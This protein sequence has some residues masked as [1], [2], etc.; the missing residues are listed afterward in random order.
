MCVSTAAFIYRSFCSVRAFVLFD[1]RAGGPSGA[2]YCVVHIYSCTMLLSSSALLACRN[3]IYRWHASLPRA[4]RPGRPPYVPASFPVPTCTPGS[5]GASAH[6]CA[7]ALL[8]V[9][10]TCSFCLWLLRFV[11]HALVCCFLFLAPLLCYVSCICQPSITDTAAGLVTVWHG[12]SEKLAF[13]TGEV[14][15]IDL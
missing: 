2:P 7:L 4:R 11:A 9:G 12:C 13:P 5:T 1:L 8:V 15:N 14:Q 10:A 6:R 3:C